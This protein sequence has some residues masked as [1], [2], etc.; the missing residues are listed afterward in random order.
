MLFEEVA[1]KFQACD[2]V[3]FVFTAMCDSSQEIV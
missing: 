3:L 2:L 1:G